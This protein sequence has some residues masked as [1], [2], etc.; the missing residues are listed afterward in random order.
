M[1]TAEAVWNKSSFCLMNGVGLNEDSFR[2]AYALHIPYTGMWD[3]ISRGLS[4]VLISPD[5]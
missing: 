1:Y 5:N 4:K 3:W 2:E